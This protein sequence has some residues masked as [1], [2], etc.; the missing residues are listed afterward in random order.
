M[1]EGWEGVMFPAILRLWNNEVLANLDSVHK[2][3]AGELGRITPTQTLPHQG[4][5]P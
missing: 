1:G 5:G 4:A 3:I 2:T